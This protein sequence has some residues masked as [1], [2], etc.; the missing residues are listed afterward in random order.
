MD[1][2]KWEEMMRAQTPADGSYPPGLVDAWGE[3]LFAARSGDEGDLTQERTLD[4]LFAHPLLFPL[5]RR[6]EMDRMHWIARRQDHASLASRQD[7]RPPE[8]VMEIGADKGGSLWAWL[9]AVPGIKRMIA[10]EVRGT[11]Y[12]D[13]FERAFPSV[14]FLWLEGSSHES[15]T[16]RR[17]ANWLT[18]ISLIEGRKTLIDRLFIDG[19]KS[20]MALDFARYVPLCEPDGIV[21]FHDVNDE[22][23]AGP[24]PAKDFERCCRRSVPGTR[25]VDGVHAYRNEV[26]LDQS[27]SRVAR[28]RA[29]EG[30]A[31]ANPHEGWLRHW[32]GRSCG[33]GV[34]WLDGLIPTK[35]FTQSRGSKP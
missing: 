2:L 29:G 12:R 22:P 17:V 21:F 24:C 8:T 15:E 26:I 11:P 7:G 31:P 6:R 1:Y 14:R 10:C 32:N 13:H 9:T 25:G 5:Q 16:A 20:G 35:T 4:D 30:L 19:D 27:E 28:L 33:V 23:W 18:E 34:I 3:F